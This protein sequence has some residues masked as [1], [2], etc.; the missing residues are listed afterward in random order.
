MADFI[1]YH[2]CAHANDDS[3][4][5][6]QANCQALLTMQMLGLV[7]DTK[8]DALAA[9]HKRM[10]RLPSR[11]GGNGQVFWDRTLACALSNA[12]KNPLDAR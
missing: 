12:G 4:D 7:S 10:L 11:Y 8:L 2:E 3:I 5:E 1:F 9:T 6:I